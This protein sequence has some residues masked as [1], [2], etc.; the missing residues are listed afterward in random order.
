MNRQR[1]FSPTTTDARGWAKRLISVRTIVLV[2]EKCSECGT[3]LD[4]ERSCPAC[5]DEKEAA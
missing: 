5:S 2:T 1:A 4:A 3:Y